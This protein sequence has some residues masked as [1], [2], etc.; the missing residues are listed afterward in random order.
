MPAAASRAE[1]G[2]LDRLA[3]WIAAAELRP[4]R[5]IR[6]DARRLL[7]VGAGCGRRS[8]AAVRLGYRVVALE[9]DGAEADR[10]R[11]C[12]GPRAVVIQGTLEAA[13]GL[14]EADVVLAW[15]VLEHLRDPDA[16]LV[17]MRRRLAPGGVVLVAVP[18]TASAEA[19]IFGGRWHGWEPSRHRWHLDRGILRRLMCEAGFSEVSVRPEGG[20]R[21]P[22][23]LAYSLVPSRDPQIATGARW[24]G[25]AIAASLV[26]LAALL[27]WLRLGPQLIATGRVPGSGGIRTGRSRRATAS[28]MGPRSGQRARDA[29]EPGL[30]PVRAHGEPG[31]R[32]P[33]VVV[34]ALAH[35]AGV[36]EEAVADASHERTVSVAADDAVGAQLGG[37]RLERG[38]RSVLTDRRRAVLAAAVQHHHPGA[39][40]VESR[41]GG[42]RLEVPDAR[43]GQTVTGPRA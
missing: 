40:M 24:L 20:W 17:A 2:L 16:A 4:L 25:P 26:P 18:N 31:P 37:Q 35:A 22:A 13:T 41:E 10:A 38:R 30:D 3:V 1:G 42:Q 5:K 29:L 43:L 34:L 14:G 23:S 28:G 32:R 36:H 12:L 6:I 39:A 8:L 33:P 9:P 15:H 7:D 21:Y 19:R 11:R 27:S